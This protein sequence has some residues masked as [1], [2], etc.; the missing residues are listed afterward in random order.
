MI[1]LN[2]PTKKLRM[3]RV[4]KRRRATQRKN[5]ESLS[6]QKDETL[7]AGRGGNEVDVIHR[8]EKLL[9]IKKKEMEWPNT[10]SN[11]KV[12]PLRTIP[13][14]PLTL[15]VFQKEQVRLIKILLI[16]LKNI[17]P[18]HSSWFIITL[19]ADAESLAEKREQVCIFKNEIIYLDMQ[20]VLRNY[21]LLFFI[22]NNRVWQ[23]GE[24][25]K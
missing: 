10:L 12:V 23:R 15:T 22:Q 20:N 25:K 9:K 21:F 8:V 11:G 19:G 14:K 17:T 5:N 2:R 24:Q 1:S 4:P 13:G 3:V 18:S 7:S 16:F 6:D